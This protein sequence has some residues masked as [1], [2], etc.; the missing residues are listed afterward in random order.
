MER[1]QVSD[2]ANIYELWNCFAACLND[3]DLVSWISL[4]ADG[5]IQ[6]PPGEPRRVGKSEIL[7]GAEAQSKRF[8]ISRMIIHTEEVRILADRAYA[9]GAFE[10]TLA[11]KRGGVTKRYRGKFLDILAKQIDGTWKLAVDCFNY[12]HGETTGPSDDNYF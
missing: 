12:D 1:L 2:V 8:D 5:A 9:H 4:W 7:K 10:F 11:P 6:M 3:G